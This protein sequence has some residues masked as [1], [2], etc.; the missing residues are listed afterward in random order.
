M[1]RIIHLFGD[2]H[3]DMLRL[4]PWYVT[5]QIEP[6]ERD[7]V[8][9]H[10]ADCADCREEVQAE[11]R[12]QSAVAGLPIGFDSVTLDESEQEARRVERPRAPLV[13]AIRRRSFGPAALGWFLAGQ[14]AVALLVIAAIAPP[15]QET[16]YHGLGRSTVEAPGSMIVIFRP[17][18]TEQTIR[19]A[20]TGIGARI[21]NGP[22]SAGAYIVSAPGRKQVSVLRHLRATPAIV[23]AQPMDAEIPR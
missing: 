19:G 12:L 18:A 6:T 15:R 16:L 11:R 14:C 4:L 21:V 9:A 22:T 23:L 10:L 8:M 1:G 7:A 20:L 2:R 13:T 5:G 3:Q 17:D